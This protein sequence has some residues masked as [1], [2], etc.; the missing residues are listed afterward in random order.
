[1]IKFTSLSMLFFAFIFSFALSPRAV[2]AKD[3]HPNWYP[4]KHLYST[5]MPGKLKSPKFFRG[6][7]R[8]NFYVDGAQ[9]SSMLNKELSTACSLGQ[10]NQIKKRRN[11]V[12]LRMPNDQVRRFGFA[13]GYGFNLRDKNFKRLET[14]IYLFDLDGTSECLVYSMPAP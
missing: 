11:F 2:H 10:F 5:L 12:N 7:S 1:M 14:E 8:V 9:L 3:G 6:G 4:L 13:N